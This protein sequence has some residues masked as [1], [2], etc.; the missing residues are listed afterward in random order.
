MWVE[1]LGLLLLLSVVFGGEQEDTNIL[2]TRVGRGIIH[3]SEHIVSIS[4]QHTVLKRYILRYRSLR[5]RYSTRLLARTRMNSSA[6][7]REFIYSRIRGSN[8]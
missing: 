4:L 3:V 5:M 8:P 7:A 6:E 2:C 1:R